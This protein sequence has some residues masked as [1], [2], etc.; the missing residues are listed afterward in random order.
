M[1]V[2][3]LR[4]D[5]V[6]SEVGAQQSQAKDAGLDGKA[7]RPLDD[8]LVV[9]SD[10]IEQSEERSVRVCGVLGCDCARE[11]AAGR[12]DV[13]CAYY[14]GVNVRRRLL[15]PVLID[16]AARSP[17]RD[18]VLSYALLAS[19]IKDAQPE[20]SGVDHYAQ[21]GISGRNRVVCPVDLDMAVKM[22]PPLKNAIVLEA[23]WR[24]RQQSR[25]FFLEHLAHLTFGGSVD[26]RGRPSLV[27]PLEERVLL[28][29]AFEMP[30][31]ERRRLRVADGGLDFALEIWRIRSTRQGDD[32]VMG[33]HRCVQRVDFRVVNVR[34][35]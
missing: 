23:R 14:E 28:I 13:G 2:V 21:T 25:A 8:L 19:G 4:G 6:L 33:Q 7:A 5:G 15:W 34:L 24:Q 20:L 30:P 16:G 18:R 31:L 32:A 26:A 35:D 10:K 22:D 3:E 1:V 11:R 17:L 29:D 9:S 12:A 27:P